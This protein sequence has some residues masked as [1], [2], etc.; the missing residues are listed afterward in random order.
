MI[1]CCTVL[2]LTGYLCDKYYKHYWRAFFD[3]FDVVY[4]DSTY[5]DGIY[6]GDSRVHFGINPKITDSILS[7]NTYNIGIGG[8]NIRENIFLTQRYLENH[9]PPAFAIFSVG[10]QGILNPTHSFVNPCDYLFYTSNE[11]TDSVLAK[12]GY[13]TNLFKF[14]PVLK[15]T[16]FDDFNKLS[17]AEGIKGNTIVSKKGISYKGF[18]NNQTNI[19]NLKE[20]KNEHDSEAISYKYFSTLEKF[21]Q[22]LKSHNILPIVVYPPGYS[23]KSVEKTI[24][25]KKVDSVIFRYSKKYRFPI[26]HFDTDRSFTEV[27]F[28]D[29]WH[30]NIN[31]TV[32]YSRKIADSILHSMR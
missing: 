13:H 16:A 15:Y 9:R 28:S 6:I 17:I 8:A 31:G 25:E 3:K 20:L 23:G 18:I 5:Y 10:Y 7:M 11:A 26:Y 1:V 29:Q 21:I 32:I 22:L 27:L 30:L 14:I 4:H 24:P 12:E 19:F 2:Y